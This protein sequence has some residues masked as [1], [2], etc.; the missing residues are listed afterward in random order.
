MTRRCDLHDKDRDPMGSHAAEQIR[1][2]PNAQPRPNDH[3]HNP[4]N[5]W[6]N[7]DKSEH[8]KPTKH[9]QKLCFSAP[10]RTHDPP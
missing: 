3:R 7:R 2:N 5:P 10:P 8:L 1:T 6:T 9:R 4:D